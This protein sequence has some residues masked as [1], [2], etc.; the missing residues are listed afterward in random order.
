VSDRLPRDRFLLRWS[1]GPA[2][3][4]YTVRLSTVALS[5]LLE[6]DGLD[7]A[8]LLVPSAALERAQAG[9][10]LLWQIETRLPDGRRIN[11]ATFVV[12]LQ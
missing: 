5:L 12:T 7:G 2:G 9:D 3:S 10:Q 1:P 4:T 8:E 6:Q 11:S